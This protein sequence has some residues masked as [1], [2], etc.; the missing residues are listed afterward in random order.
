CQCA[1]NH[2]NL[3]CIWR[4]DLFVYR[5][6]VFTSC[7]LTGQPRH[8]ENF[9]F[10]SC[11]YV[12]CNVGSKKTPNNK[13]M[14]MQ[15][16]AKVKQQYWF[17][18]MAAAVGLMLMFA[19]AQ[20]GRPMEVDDAGI[21]GAGACELEAWSEHRR[22]SNSYWAVPACN[23]TGNL[24]IGL[25]AAIDDHRHGT[26]KTAVMEV[27]SVVA[28]GLGG[29]SDMALALA[30]ERG[31]FRGERENEWHLNLPITTFFASERLAWHNNLGTLYAEDEKHHAFA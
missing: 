28:E 24:E 15:Y 19:D 4:G 27:K 1:A 26:V 14:T 16:L 25:G 20:A 30:F 22:H 13:R 7:C 29:H 11:C 6:P 23:V 10:G 2:F 18:H 31:H 21:V 3:R 5:H 9:P 17:M 8:N 12:C